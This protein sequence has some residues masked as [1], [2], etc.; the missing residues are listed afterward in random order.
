MLFYHMLCAKGTYDIKYAATPVKCYNGQIRLDTT[1]DTISGFVGLTNGLYVTTTGY[2]DNNLLLSGE[3]KLRHAN[4]LGLRS[5]LILTSSA[6]LTIGSTAY[7]I[8]FIR[9]NGGSIV[10]NG[11]LTIPANRTLHISSNT[12][13]DGQDNQLLVDANAQ[14]FVDDNVTLTLRNLVLKDRQHALT[15]PPVRLASHRSKL[16]LDN[17]VLAPGRDFLFPQGQFFVHN[18]VQFTGTSAFIYTSPVPSWI[19]SGGCLYFD[20]GTTFSI[21]PAT[22]TDAPRNL[23]YIDCNFIKMADKSSQLY[24]NGCNVTTTYTGVRFTDGNVMF[25]NNVSLLSGGIQNLN[26]AGVGSRISGYTFSDGWVTS[27]KWSPDGKYLAV[28]KYGAITYIY[29]FNGVAFDRY[30]AVD[31]AANTGCVDWSPDGK[32]LAVANSGSGSYIYPFDGYSVGQKI[33]IGSLTVGYAVAWSPD[34]KFIALGNDATSNSYVYSFDGAS[35]GTQIQF[36]VVSN[37]RALA[38]SP[39]G[40]YLAAAKYNA[41]CY[42]YP[43]TGVSFGAGIVI[44]STNRFSMTIAWSPDGKYVA[45]GNDSLQ[46]SYVY[47]FNGTSIVGSIIFSWNYGFKNGMGLAWSPDGNYIALANGSNSG[48]S[49]IY[50]FNRTACTELARIDASQVSSRAVAWHPSGNFVALGNYNR[51]VSCYR[52]TYSHGANPQA[53]SKS[54]V[55]GDSIKGAE[56]D[57]DVNILNGAEIKLTGTMYYDCVA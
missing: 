49:Y 13:I 3:L 31:I 43:F 30:V 15:V 23:S 8:A 29:A 10:L 55:F 44:D 41:V 57:V 22:F 2:W 32:Y 25:D 53:L 38:W 37:N 11:P 16:A 20:H 5:D 17:V 52:I 26:Q 33:Q 14:I 6:W 24:L 9:G 39:D 34:G 50:T 48:N 56:R 40:K 42:I 27:V 4:S 12:I 1:N 45:I 21:A 46:D 7:D 35:C 51:T 28:G 36:G 18:D 47:Q 54:I 19:T